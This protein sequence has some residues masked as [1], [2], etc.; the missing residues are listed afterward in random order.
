MKKL[1]I[2]LFAMAIAVGTFAAFAFSPVTN[3]VAQDDPQYH[4]FDANTEAYLGQRTESQQR[5]LCGP[6]GNIPC[7]D[8]YTA[9][10]GNSP[11]GSFITTMDKQ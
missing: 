7:A 1:N 2:S 9:V 8:A 11:A 10:S 6:D 5:V 4:W 3:A